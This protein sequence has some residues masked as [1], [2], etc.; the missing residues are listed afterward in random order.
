MIFVIGIIIVSFLYLLLL[1]F[2]CFFFLLINELVVIS[3]DI[4][5]LKWLKREI[6]EPVGRGLL[7]LIHRNN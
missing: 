4:D 3:F 1:S 5:L 7:E 6:F 2:S